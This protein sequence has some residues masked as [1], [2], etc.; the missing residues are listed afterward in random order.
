[1]VIQPG[2][3]LTSNTSQARHKAANQGVSSSLDKAQS[4]STSI[5]STE[6]NVQLSPEAQT[7]E[8]LEAK[9]TASEGVDSAKV[10]QI[11]QQIAEGSY[12]INSQRLAENIVNQ[13]SLLGG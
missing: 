8:R 12:E 7:I 2:N 5:A 10:E 3:D 13:D 11:K 4:A 6:K 1:M 9:I